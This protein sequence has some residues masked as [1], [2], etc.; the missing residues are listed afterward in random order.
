TFHRRRCTGTV[1]L[2]W[3]GQGSTQLFF[4]Q[5]GERGVC[6]ETNGQV[7]VAPGDRLEGSGFVQIKENFGMLHAAVV[8]KIGTAPRPAPTPIDR[9][10][11]LGSVVLGRT[12]TDA[13]D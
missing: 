11:V 2:V 9:R 5:E 3:P 12:V 13:R 7:P 10:L 4:L 1:T 6:V 8:R